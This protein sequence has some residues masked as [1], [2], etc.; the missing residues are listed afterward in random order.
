MT[1]HCPRCDADIGDS[2]EPDDPSVGIC[3]GWYCDACDLA[4]SEWEIDR[5][6]LEGDVEIPPMPRR[7][8]GKLG[9]PISEL[10]GQ[11]GP[12]DDIG[13]PDHARYAEFCRI[14]RSWG[15]E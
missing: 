3:G 12:A 2:Y 6:P 5:E 14:A 8:D 9:T 10:S 11:P 7:P 1:V 15:F 4:I 13:H